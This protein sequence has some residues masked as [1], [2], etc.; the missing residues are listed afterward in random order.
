MMTCVQVIIPAGEQ[1]VTP[2]PERTPESVRAV[3]AVVDAPALPRFDAEWADAVAL[4]REEGSVLPVRRFTEEWWLW[5]A[6]HAAARVRAA[7]RKVR[8]QVAGPGSGGRDRGDPERGGGRPRV[9]GR[10]RVLG[11]AGT[12][13]AAAH[14][15]GS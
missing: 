10:A 3:I 8:R 15:P 14:R 13:A 7:R 5:A 1:P 12:A 9:S 11:R 6:G 4:A 2:K